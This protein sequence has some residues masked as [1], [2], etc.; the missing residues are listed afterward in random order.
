MTIPVSVNAGAVDRIVKETYRSDVIPE[1]EGRLG[2]S[3]LMHMCYSARLTSPPEVEVTMPGA[4]TVQVP[5]EGLVSIPWG[6]GMKYHVEAS[7]QVG[8]GVEDGKLRLD[9]GELTFQDLRLANGCSF[10]RKV[11]HLIGPFIYG[12]IF[13]GLFG[14]DGLPL[15]DLPPI[16]IPL[17]GMMPELSPMLELPSVE[18]KIAGVEIEPPGVIAMVEMDGD[19]TPPA[20]LPAQEGWDITVAISE[21]TADVMVGKIMDLMGDVRGNLSFPVPDPRAMAD[22]LFASA[23]TLTTLGRRGLGRR[24]FRGTSSIRVEYTARTGRPSLSFQGGDKIA[25]CRIPAHINAK[26]FLEVERSKRGFKDR[27]M[28]FFR[29]SAVGDPQ[30]EKVDMGSWDFDG[31]FNIERA[32]VTVRQEPGSLPHLDLTFLDLDLELPWPFPNE[33]LE[34]LTEGLG[35][36]IIASRLPKEFPTEIPLSPEIPFKLKLKE[37]RLYAHEGTMDVR[38]NIDLLPGG[39]TDDVKKV[40]GDR[41]NAVTAQMLTGLSGPSSR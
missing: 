41:M 29:P 28:A 4:L 21:A 34:K 35:K 39:S 27:L 31:D 32:E 16:I 3:D 10:P 19:D 5:V 23:E 7:T 14:K 33:V 18:L 40:L 30:T 38:A 15:V 20:T 11:L 13:R 6:M 26:A 22:V 12:A 25:I 36:D 8:V 9:V 17:S 2:R 24:K 37:L 1:L